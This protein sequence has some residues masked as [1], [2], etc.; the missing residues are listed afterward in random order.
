[1][2]LF[3][4]RKEKLQNYE[5]SANAP[6]NS[7]FSKY[8]ASKQTYCSGGRP[9]LLTNNVIE[10]EKVNPKTYKIVRARKENVKFLV[11]TSHKHFISNRMNR[12]KE[13]KMKKRKT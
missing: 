12:L 13:K 4:P 7:S 10:Y 11:E 3:K 5:P 9:L 8:L 1:M 6:E 2:S